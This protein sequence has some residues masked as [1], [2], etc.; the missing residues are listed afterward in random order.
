MTLDE[1]ILEVY[2]ITNRPDRST[3]TLSGIKAAT[4]K[5]HQSDHYFKDLYESGLAFDSA[6][7]VQDLDYRTLLPRWRQPKYFRKYDNSTGT[8][9]IIL[10]KIEPENV[11]DEYKLQKQDIYYSAGAYIHINSSTQEQYYLFGAYLNPDITT[12]GYNSWVALDHPFAIIYEAAA[13]VFKSIGKDEEAATYRQMVPE[14]IQMIR[15]D[16]IISGDC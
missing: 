10:T 9:G 16:S 8:P 1:L 2:S 3:E 14:Q 4:L 12:A 6:A 15:M 11:L 7:Y 5:A 13:F